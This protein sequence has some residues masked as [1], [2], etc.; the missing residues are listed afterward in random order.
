VDA[1]KLGKWDDLSAYL[2]E[3]TE[4]GQTVTLKLVRDGK[5]LTVSVTLADTPESLR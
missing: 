2:E 5:E 4:V 1:V 3:K